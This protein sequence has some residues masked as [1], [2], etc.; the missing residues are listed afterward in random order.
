MGTPPPLLL[1]APLLLLSGPVLAKARPLGPDYPAN[2]QAPRWS[3]DGSQ[4]AY[5]V[6]YHDKKRIELFLLT[7][8]GGEPR[9]VRP[10]SRGASALTAGFSTSGTASVVHEISFA[11][12]KIGRFAYSASS[13]DQ[14]YDIFI[15][16]TGAIAHSNF[17]DGEPAWS[18]DGRYIA[19]A[20]ARTGQGDIYLIDTWAVDEAPRRITSMPT[21]SEVYVTWDPTSKIL[22]FVAHNREG[23]SLYFVEP[24][25]KKAP[26]LVTPWG[27][28]Q[29][30]PSF[31]P[32]GKY[33]AFYSN[34]DAPPRF[35]LYVA[36]LG[37][38]ATLI[39]A[40][41]L[42]NASGPS[43]TPDS[44][45]LVFVK[46]DDSRFDPVLIAP[47]ANPDNVRVV[48][49]AT[50]GNGD[51]DVA[52]GTDGRFYLVVVAQ[53]IAGDKQRDFKRLYVMEVQP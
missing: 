24:F 50:V 32:D 5:E 40:D 9:E 4:V 11:P 41:V 30:R 2:C 8:G 39:A 21:S 17:P 1:L 53:G 14:D 15:D 47:I 7:P 16:G 31:S 45:H 3:T 28:T 43:W 22:A 35:D 26:V 27:R 44:A 33:V 13:A 37:G 36:E 49:T 38:A 10:S 23:D 19:F 25:E 20:S 12:P 18:P 34:H 6:N 46:N 52:L 29:T 42:L 48:P 51:L